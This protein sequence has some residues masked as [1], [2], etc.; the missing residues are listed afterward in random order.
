MSVFPGRA[1][2]QNV[3]TDGDEGDSLARASRCVNMQS[4]CTALKRR[5]NRP[6]LPFSMWSNTIGDNE[7]EI[8]K[9]FCFE[10]LM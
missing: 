10:E 3:S 2:L 5:G 7:R 9:T 8:D 4:R 6:A 1:S